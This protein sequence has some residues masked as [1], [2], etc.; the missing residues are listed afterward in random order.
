MQKASISLRR[1]VLKGEALCRFAYKLTDWAKLELQ[2]W[3][4][5]NEKHLWEDIWLYVYTSF[6]PC[7]W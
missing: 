5:I 3:S 4:S 2:K 7:G 1:L 6:P